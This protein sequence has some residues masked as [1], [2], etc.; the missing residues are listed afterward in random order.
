MIGVSFP[1][2]LDEPFPPQYEHLKP[3]QECGETV[4][5]VYNGWAER[6]KIQERRR[7]LG[8]ADPKPSWFERLREWWCK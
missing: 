4:R 3:K 7:Q 8:I 1:Q 2:M 5:D 6:E